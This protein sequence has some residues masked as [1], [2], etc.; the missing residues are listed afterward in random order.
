MAWNLE[1][2]IRICNCFVFT[3]YCITLL[4]VITT[5]SHNKNDYR[6]SKTKVPVLFSSAARW[7]RVYYLSRLSSTTIDLNTSH[8][9]NERIDRRIIEFL[10]R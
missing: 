4:S 7:L 2:G 5:K 10:N 6:L 3:V 8:D 9:Y 1:I